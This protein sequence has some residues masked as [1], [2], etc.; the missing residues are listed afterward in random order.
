MTGTD[1]TS[2]GI[3]SV[4]DF[5]I[6]ARTWLAENYPRAEG[7]G[8]LLRAGES[9]EAE[10]A[11]IAH[12][13]E[14]QRRLFDGGLAGVCFP[15]EYGGQ[16]LTPDHQRALNEECVGYEIPRILQVPT[17]VPCAAVLLEFGTEEQK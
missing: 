15:T 16:G 7:N 3:E 14:L 4:E 11:E 12:A 9:E 6:R 1:T 13:R 17:F 5:R 10:L 8:Q 2:V